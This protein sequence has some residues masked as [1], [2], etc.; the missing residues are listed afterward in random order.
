MSIVFA[1]R[2]CIVLLKKHLIVADEQMSTKADVLPVCTIPRGKCINNDLR[3]AIVAARHS[4]KEYKTIPK[5]LR[6]QQYTVRKV[7]ERHLRQLAI[8]PG[9]DVLEHLPLWSDIAHSML[10]ETQKP[11]K[12]HFRPYM[13]QWECYSKWY[14]PWQQNYKKTE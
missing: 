7:C 12:L 6:R 2:I 14:S 1:K 8:F 13:P 10:K 4:G 11:Q 5:Q 9:I 3:E